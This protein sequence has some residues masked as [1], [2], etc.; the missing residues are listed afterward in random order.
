MENIIEN[1]KSQM[2]MVNTQMLQGLRLIE[3][4][5]EIYWQQEIL[6]YTETEEKWC[7]VAGFDNYVVS[8][9]GR[10]INI[11]TGDTPKLWRD[12]KSYALIRLKEGEKDIQYL[13]HRLIAFTFIENVQINNAPCVDHINHNPYDNRVVNLRWCT[14]QQNSMNK[15]KQNHTT[16]K[17]KGVYYCKSSKKWK[18]Q[19]RHN[20]TVM[21]LGYYNTESEAGRAYN[22]KAIELFGEFACLNVF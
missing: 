21:S 13:L 15:S 7:K 22:Y 8:T 12:H 14:Y 17:Y 9:L 19:I 3:A 4:I 6:K 5:D 20:R 2:K 18:A 10:F 1:Y 11:T 16:S